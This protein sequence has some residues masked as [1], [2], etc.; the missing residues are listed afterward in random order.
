YPKEEA[1][2]ATVMLDALKERAMRAID[3]DEDLPDDEA[4]NTLKEALSEVVEVA[5]A[6]VAQGKID[7]GALVKLEPGAVTLAAGA[8]VADAPR[9][10][11]AIQKIVE[12]AKQDPN[13]PA[14]EWNAAKYEGVRFHT[15]RVPVPEDEEEARKIL[16]DEM[17]VVLGVGETSFYVALGHHG[18]DTI[19]SV[20]DQSKAGADRTVAPME[21]A[22]S[23]ARIMKFAASQADDPTISQ[24]A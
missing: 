6:T 17:E 2:Q 13:F 8:H 18:I 3:E 9:L 24:V 10:E 14:V 4:R 15:A 5:K 1:E 21:L 12:L 11:K 7:G 16:G 23:L 19:K 20:I 22:L